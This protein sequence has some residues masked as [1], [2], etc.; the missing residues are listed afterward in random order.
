MPPKCN[1]LLV[2]QQNKHRAAIF[3]K[4]GLPNIKIKVADKMYNSIKL[5]KIA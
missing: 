3:K 5:H 2:K 1:A 4:I